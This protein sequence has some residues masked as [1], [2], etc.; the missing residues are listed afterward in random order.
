MK[1]PVQINVYALY[2]GGSYRNEISTLLV[3]Q[4]FITGVTHTVI[5]LRNK[6]SNNTEQLYDGYNPFCH[7]CDPST[8]DR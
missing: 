8:S 3:T 1:V 5:P 4:W 7:S 6:L 2:K